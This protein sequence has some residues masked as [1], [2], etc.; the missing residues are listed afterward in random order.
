MVQSHVQKFF[1]SRRVS[2]VNP[3]NVNLV[4]VICEKGWED[5]IATPWC[6]LRQASIGFNIG[7]WCVVDFLDGVC[8]ET[9]ITAVKLSSTLKSELGVVNLVVDVLFETVVT[10]IH[11][12][13]VRV[14]FHVNTNRRVERISVINRDTCVVDNNKV[15][16]RA[17]SCVFSV[18]TVLSNSSGN[19]R[20]PTWV[21]VHLP[22]W[23][24]NGHV[25]LTRVVRG[26][27]NHCFYKER[28]LACTAASGW[29]LVDLTTSVC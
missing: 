3:C 10:T 27:V 4:L 2:R 8:G 6:I 19:T 11:P 22:V 13:N 18:A 7:N 25:D 15:S 9:I 23:V 14:A 5:G 20:R 1:T 12:C 28:H 16:L 24:K 21:V 29:E 26:D 17:L